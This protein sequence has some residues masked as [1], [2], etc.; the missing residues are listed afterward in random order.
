MI[1]KIYFDNYD[2]QDCY[3]YV[4]HGDGIE[5]GITD[6]G[7]AIQYILINT[8]KGVKDICLGYPTISERVES[9]TYCGATIGR[10]ANRIKNSHFVLG[11]KPYNLSA[12][13]GKNCNHGGENGF[14]KRLFEAEVKGDILLLKLFSEDGDQGFPGN[15]SLTVQ[16]N[17]K[18]KNLEVR[19]SA[20]SD[21][22]TVWAPTNHLCFNLNGEDSGCILDTILKINADEITPL[23]FNQIP[24]GDK[25]FVGGT[26]FDYT[27]PCPIGLYINKS[28]EQLIL[29]KGYDHNYILKNSHAATAL[30]AESGIKMD[31]YTDLPGLQFYSGNFLKG[32]GKSGE[33]HPRDG[34]CLE[35]QYFPNAVNEKNFISPVLKA[36]CKK[37]YYI[38][39]EFTTIN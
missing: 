29:A 12:N 9:G 30:N 27:K 7:A 39:Y 4:L 8:K 6:F 11:E 16:F 37:N 25:M 23:D 20:E 17:L 33:Y 13:D 1:D 32:N 5:V 18:G 21:E 19:Y 24:D 15:L 36:N 34:I 38:R 35:P 14:D 3:L 26:P 2:G 22:D 10:V 28:D 31:L